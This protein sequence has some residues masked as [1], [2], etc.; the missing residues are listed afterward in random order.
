MYEERITDGS[1]DDR[2]VVGAAERASI[3]IVAKGVLVTEA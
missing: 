2:G 1:I 3:K